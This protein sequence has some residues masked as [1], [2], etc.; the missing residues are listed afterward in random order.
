MRPAAVG[1][2]VAGLVVLLL[3]TIIGGHDVGPALRIAGIGIW[4]LFGVLLVT[5]FVIARRL[6]Q[7]GEKIHRGPMLLPASLADEAY[8]TTLR[9]WLRD[10]HTS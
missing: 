3:G 5:N 4:V 2:W 6:E 8:V 1:V 10:R 9:R 7:L